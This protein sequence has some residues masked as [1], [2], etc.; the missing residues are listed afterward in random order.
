MN[1]FEF[2]DILL[3]QICFKKVSFRLPSVHIIYELSMYGKKAHSLH[4]L[5]FDEGICT[6]V[7]ILI[8]AREFGI[9]QT[10][11]YFLVLLWRFPI[12]NHPFE[13]YHLLK[14]IFDYLTLKCT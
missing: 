14:V 2:E 10:T 6:F 12:G 8:S 1:A 4:I 9:T 11:I 7:A 13:T 3:P 5:V